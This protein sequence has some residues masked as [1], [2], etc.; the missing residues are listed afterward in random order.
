MD[1]NIV[2][3]LGES[4][5]SWAFLKDKLLLAGTQLAC[6][7]FFAGAVYGVL[8]GAS[9]PGT[10]IFA[11]LILA[12]SAWGGGVLVSCLKLPPLL[13]MLAVGIFFRNAPFLPYHADISIIWASTLRDISLVI[14][15]LKAGLGLDP[16]KLLELKLDVLKLSFIPCLFE[17]ACSAVLVHYFL[18]LPW[19]WAFMLGFIVS[20][21]S[22]AV[23]VPGMLDLEEKSL[24]LEAGIPT[25]LMAAVSL[26][27]ITALTGFIV[28][29]S[30]ITSNENLT[31]TLITR[32]LEPFIGLLF[33]TIMGVILWYLPSENTSEPAQV[34]YR[35]SSLFLGGLCFTF[36]SKQVGMAGAG[37]LAC[38][39]FAFI[40][41]LKWRT[42]EHF[43]YI[44]YIIGIMWNLIEPFLFGLIGAEITLNSLGNNLGYATLA[45]CLGVLIRVLSTIF[46]LL[47]SKLNF[48]EK[49]FVSAS[50]IAKATV[51]AAVGS[52]AL[53]Y[54]RSHRTEPNFKEYSQ[55]VLMMSVL[56]IILTAPLG[57]AFID[58]LAPHL[59]NAGYVTCCSSPDSSG[60][61]E[62]EQIS[63]VTVTDY[64]AR[65]SASV[66]EIEGFI[67]GL[68][69]G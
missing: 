57:A 16:P 58:W 62:R 10:E 27:N 40:A 55:Q 43:K 59:L 20:A 19:I 53:D 45:L 6:L 54:A 7:L 42:Q 25:L 52:Q 31:W 67:R 17:A 12:A 11:L 4:R 66:G 35:S 22:A 33:G 9:Q 63:E 30:I 24:G 21:V 8:G 64:G 56:S 1:K 49:T 3:G 41:S 51:Q 38:V 34:F 14:I 28:T 65:R 68:R 36:V 2:S 26:D 37:A 15:L 61:E 18:E 32:P 50:W 48:K 46:A 60:E 44:T 69:S 5:C 23:L 13:G 39:S 29:F 47:G